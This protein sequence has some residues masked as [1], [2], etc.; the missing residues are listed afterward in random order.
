MTR[1]YTNKNTKKFNY[2]STGVLMRRDQGSSSQKESKEIVNSDW[3]MFEDFRVP[4]CVFV[5]EKIV[6]E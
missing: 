5:D 2:K 4:L 3:G 1:K 6:H